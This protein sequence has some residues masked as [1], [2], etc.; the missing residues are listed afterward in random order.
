MNDLAAVLIAEGA[1]AA[2]SEEEYLAAWQ[3][4]VDTGLVWRLQGTFGRTA[5]ALLLA[6]M[7]QP[8]ARKESRSRAV[9][10]SRHEEG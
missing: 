3:R 2:A 10:D 6:G 8:A 4:L 9:T 7:I 1:E 5:N